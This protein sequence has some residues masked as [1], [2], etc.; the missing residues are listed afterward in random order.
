VGSPTGV[1]VLRAPVGSAPPV[2]SQ[3]FVFE[4]AFG[5]MGFGGGHSRPLDQQLSCSRGT[6]AADLPGSFLYRAPQS[7]AYQ[8]RRDGTDIA[9]AN[10]PRYIPSA[11]GSYTCRVTATNRAGSASQTSAP[12]TVS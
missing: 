9:G 12:F 4:Q 10:L 5:G 3:S 6:W 2:I 7:L 1:A 11:P 8:W